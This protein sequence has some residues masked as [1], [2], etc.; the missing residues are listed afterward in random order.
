MNG[1]DLLILAIIIIAAVLAART[2]FRKKE[3][4][5]GCGGCIHRTSC[6]KAQYKQES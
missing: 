5:C 3:C 4:S 2:A 6:Q 1:A